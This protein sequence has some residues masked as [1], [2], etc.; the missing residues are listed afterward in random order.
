MMRIPVLV[1]V[2]LI[3]LAAPVSSSYAAD[4]RPTCLGQIATIVGGDAR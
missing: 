4:E 2:S 1:A 3:V